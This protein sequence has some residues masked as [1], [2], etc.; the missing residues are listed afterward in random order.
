MT[1][2]KSTNHEI[3][4]ELDLAMIIME[5][6]GEYIPPGREVRVSIKSENEHGYS[7]TI[8]VKLNEPRLTT[9]SWTAKNE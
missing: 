3:E 4:V 8:Y 1:T 7:T 6:S 5:K 2:K 9:V